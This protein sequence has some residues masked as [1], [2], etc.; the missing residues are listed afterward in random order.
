[1]NR[2]DEFDFDDRPS[3]RE[4]ILV[5]IVA[6]FIIAVLAGILLWVI[7]KPKTEV[8]KPNV[9]IGESVSENIEETL[10]GNEEKNAIENTEE[11]VSKPDKTIEREILLGTGPEEILM[12]AKGIDVSK[13]QGNINW[14]EV[15]E[16]G[17]EFA[18]VRV[19]YRT[20][21]NGAIV[22]DS[23][24]RYNLQEATANGIKVGVY[25]FS[26]AISETEAVEEA[27]WVVELIDQYKITYPVAYNCEGY[28]DAKSRQYSLN[29]EE[30]TAC[31][32]A[33]LDEI[34]N[35]GYT[36][37]FYASKAEMED[38]NQWIVSDLDKSYK[39]WVSWY[40]E[41]AYPETLQSGYNGVHCMWQYSNKGTVD[42]IN[43]PVDLN[44]AYF[45]Y[46][47]EANAKN[48][49]PPDK[50]TVNTE[51]GHNFT[52]VNEKVTAKEATNLRTIPSQGLDS[53][54]VV[55]LKNGEIITR[56]GVSTSG[57]SRV[58]YNGNIYYAVSNLLTTDLTYTPP[59]PTEKPD[60]R[61]KTVFRERNEM[62]S[63]KMEVNLRT[64]PSVTNS[65]SVVVV[66][67]PYGS[68][69]KRTGINEELGWS[70]IEYEGQVLYCVSS[71]IYVVE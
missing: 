53:T 40:P 14:K 24:A 60:D 62:V 47:T 41:I 9:I 34:Y 51:A 19:G 3:F 43:E 54:V 65:E 17:L 45:G 22:E 48:S 27:K 42:G 61:I 6:L 39:I 2:R 8:I 29:N 63:P 66:K 69:V 5:L 57:W 31:A 4:S 50:V 37:M 12:E 70:R 20:M 13:Y 49:T 58:L 26:T 28:L 21:E 44:V 30:R 35:N 59:N 71:Y 7:K 64:L 52:E 15:A 68:I 67:L 1:M 33:F 25:F 32:K 23:L 18:M 46:E 38:D 55:T 11:N 56:T 16:S 36:P 10:V